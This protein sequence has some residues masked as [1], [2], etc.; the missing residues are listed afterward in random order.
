MAIFTHMVVGTNDLERSKKFYNEALG[1]T[2]HVST[3]D[4]VKGRPGAVP[5]ESVGARTSSSH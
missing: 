1:S 3:Y 5:D 4:R 2:C